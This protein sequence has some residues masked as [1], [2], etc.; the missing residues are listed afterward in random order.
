MID[1]RDK[2]DLNASAPIE[3]TLLGISI[4]DIEVQP[5][6]ASYPIEVR[7]SGRMIV[8]RVFFPLK[9]TPEVFVI[10]D[11]SRTA[12]DVIFSRIQVKSS[13][14]SVPVTMSFTTKAGRWSA[15]KIKS[16]NVP[17]FS[18]WIVNEVSLFIYE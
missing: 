3:V 7:F 16:N 10:F 11:I 17:G 18:T 9:L 14:L 13:S 8:V 6:N 4:E 1:L 5:L 12:S 2:Q 15:S